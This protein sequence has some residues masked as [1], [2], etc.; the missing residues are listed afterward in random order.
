MM[1][2][3]KCQYLEETW[4]MRKLWNSEN[5]WGKAARN[6]DLRHLLAFVGALVSLVPVLN[7][8]RVGKGSLLRL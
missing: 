6:C 2:S 1:M 4:L 3:I 7:L 8:V 5:C